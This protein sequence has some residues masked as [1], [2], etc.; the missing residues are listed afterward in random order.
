[1]A[2]KRS[3]DGIIKRTFL[4]EWRLAYFF[5]MRQKD[6]CPVCIICHK[7]VTECK[8]YNL[9]RHFNTNH[10]GFNARFPMSD[11]PSRQREYDRLFRA[12]DGMSQSMFTACS[13]TDHVTDASFRITQLIVRHKK[14]FSDG[15]FVKECFLVG[16]GALYKSFHNNQQIIEQIRKMSL[17]PQTCTRRCEQISADLSAQLRTCLA[18]SPYFSLAI[19]ESTDISDTSQLLIFI[20]FFDVIIK[21]VRE[22][23]LCMKSLTGRT[24]GQDI[25]D[26][27]YEA[28]DSFGLNWQHLTSITTDGAPSMV[29]RKTGF[30]VLLRQKTGVNFLVYHC[31][32]HQQALCSKLRRGDY[33]NF[34]MVTVTKVINRI[35]NSSLQHRLFKTLLK[36]VECEYGDLILYNHI[37]WLSRGAV[38]Q[39]F[40][41]VLPQIE[42]Y[43]NDHGHGNNNDFSALEDSTFRTWLGILADMS[44]HFNVLNEKLQGKM[45][46]IF[47]LYEHVTEFRGILTLFKRQIESDDLIMF[48]NTK[49]LSGDVHEAA[50]CLSDYLDDIII[51]FDSRFTDFSDLEQV[52]LFIKDPF[53]CS[54]TSSIAEL[55]EKHFDINKAECELELVGLKAELGLKHQHAENDATSFWLQ[56]VPARFRILRLVATRI[57]VMFGSTYICESAFSNMKFIKNP[58]RSRLTD[59]HMDAILRIALS[60]FDPRFSLLVSNLQSQPSH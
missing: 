5:C 19:D 34:V 10:R 13:S 30:L 27:V 24:T 25:C 46:P 28:C 50:A 17:S 45:K 58:H 47:N 51:E 18:A 41:A 29:G 60:S 52:F 9:E 40:I 57:L 48:P 38:L 49:A 22:D 33:M 44:K 11:H 56:F 12:L 43:L 6:R 39:R 53:I 20:R 4:D 35:R 26:A 36:E 54:Q 2:S 59:E 14:P 31:I 32:I 21:C 16:A 55:F 3:S 15:E 37:R 7:T 23:L 1:M 8:K 42:K